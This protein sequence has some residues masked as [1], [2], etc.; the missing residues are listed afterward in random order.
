MVAAQAQEGGVIKP[1]SNRRGGMKIY[2]AL[3]GKF[4]AD[5]TGQRRKGAVM[6]REN[7]FGGI[8]ENNGLPEFLR[9]LFNDHTNTSATRS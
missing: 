9:K 7:C 2:C 3:C 8:T 5:M 1:G 6:L 4:V